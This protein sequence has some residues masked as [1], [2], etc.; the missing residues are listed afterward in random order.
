MRDI[1]ERLR[2]VAQQQD[3]NY[4][5]TTEEA[6]DTITALRAG[7]ERLKAGNDD[8]RHTIHQ[9]QPN[10]DALRA[11]LAELKAHHHE[12]FNVWT[13]TE[14]A[15]NAEVERLRATL[16][17]IDD[18]RHA[19]RSTI[20][21]ENAFEKAASLNKQLVEIMDRAAAALEEKT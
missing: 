12:C 17:W 20:N 5:T 13:E 11:E 6:A 15:L 14:A 2:E 1:V 18:Q 8:M 3:C 4:P 10:M 9:W 19:D 7:V 16:Q 21:F